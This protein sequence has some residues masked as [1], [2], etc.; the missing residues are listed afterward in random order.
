MRRSFHL[1]ILL[2]T[3]V[4]VSACGPSEPYEEPIPTPAPT[5]VKPTYT[6]QRGNII[7][8]EVAYGRVI[9]TIAHE[10]YFHSEGVVGQ[11]YVSV[12][13][14]VEKGQLLADLQS[15]P[16][17]ETQWTTASDQAAYE[18]IA[19]KNTIRRAEIAL[20]IAQLTLELLQSQG[21]SSYEIKIQEL[22][23]ELAQMELDETKASITASPEAVKVKELE[24]A[25]EAA[26]LTSPV[27]GTVISAIDPGRSVK[28]TT[29][30][31]MIGDVSQLE[32][33]V[34]IGDAILQE[35]SEGMPVTVTFTTSS[36]TEGSLVTGRIRQLPHPYG[37]GEGKD[38]RIALDQSPAAGGY[39]LGDTARLDIELANKNDVLWL[40][41]D[42]IRTINGRTFVIVQTPS[43]QQHI[44]IKLGI[45]TD[46]RVEVTSGLTEGQVIVGP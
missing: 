19:A 43:G 33:S 3:L 9:P 27:A 12:N 37:G 20:E 13:S 21:A 34:D 28:T 17:L 29:L 32:I 14:E 4:A 10:V 42:A 46:E 39:K 26:Q 23:V 45:Q 11:V 41:P 1:L 31:F 16:D 8:Q 25:M 22:K 36:N 6:V 24:A 44:D 5:A 18:Q 7:R 38:V 35:L 30:A 2:V 15:L 40:P